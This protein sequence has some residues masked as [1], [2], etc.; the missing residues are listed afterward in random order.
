MTAS[1]ALTKKFV[2]L[3]TEVRRLKRQA[4]Y[5]TP[6]ELV[7]ATRKYQSGLNYF[8]HLAEQQT[9]DLHSYYQTFIEL[10]A[11]LRV[12]EQLA[13]GV[14]PGEKIA[15]FIDGSNLEAQLVEKRLGARID[16]RKLLSYF[17][18]NGRILRAYYYYPIESEE[19]K[20]SKFL[21]FL[22]RNGFQVVTKLM[23]RFYDGGQKGNLDIELAIDMLELADKVDRVILFSGDGD[24]APLLRAVGRRGARTHVVSYWGRGKGITGRELFNAA[25]TFT[26]LEGIID[27]IRF[28]ENQN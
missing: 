3:V 28:P 18:M 21:V 8:Y 1:P 2:R 10:E 26:D 17:G 11:D 12:I 24:F 23:K 25:D 19:D 5:M 27:L 14:Q 16:F 15:I 20:D 22:K 4:P 13:N 6:E 9:F 7:K